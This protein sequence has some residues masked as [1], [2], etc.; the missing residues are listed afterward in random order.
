MDL[1]LY[2]RVLWRFRLLVLVGLVLAVALAVLSVARV[3]SDGLTWRKQQRWQSSTTL[4]LTQHGFPWGQISAPSDPGRFASL[5]DLY[6][7]LAGGDEVRA[8]M[9]AHGAPRSWTLTALPLTPR[10]PSAV[11]PLIALS[12]QAPSSGGAVK[13][14]M[15][16]RRAFLE[17]VAQQQASAAIPDRQRIDVQVVQNASSPTLIQPRKKTLPIV[18]L[19]AVLSA[20]VALAF[21]LENV[22]PRVRPATLKAAGT[23]D[24][25]PAA[26]R[27][28]TA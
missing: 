9:R 6:S 5:T 10:T 28:S 2:G 13:A 25:S 3:T 26:G 1:G 4:L 23:T 17:Y 19:L 20:T 12:G 18:I 22:R 16:G 21:V 7:Q 14:A 8:L 11:L 27:R 24:G 15:A